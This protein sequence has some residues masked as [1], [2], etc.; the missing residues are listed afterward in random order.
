MLV[1][2]PWER[3]AID[4]TRKHPKSRNGHEYMIT[5]MDHFTKW[6][7]VYP[8]CD[9][10]APTVAKVLVEQ[11]FSRWGMHYQ[12]LSDQGPE[13]GS[14]LFREICRAMGIDKIWT[15]PYRPA[16]NGMLERY[17]RTLNSMI[18]ENCE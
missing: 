2:E 8:L 9:R 17:H 7:E 11:R 4:I 1:G 14:E 16:C 3:V 6:A 13:F 5:V 18:G 10:K 12:L 15:S